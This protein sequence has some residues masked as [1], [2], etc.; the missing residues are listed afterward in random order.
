MNGT[1]IARLLLLLA[2]CPSID[3][4]LAQTNVGRISGTVSDASGA[5]IPG[6]TMV[7]KNTATRLEQT[8]T[9]EEGAFIFPGLASGTYDL[10]VEKEGFRRSEQIGIVLDTASTRTI[11]F[12]LEVGQLVR[13]FQYRPQSSRYRR[14]KVTW[15]TSSV[16]S[17]SARSG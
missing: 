7:A 2:V 1:L 12:K 14:L 16:T 6:C 4:A 15:G 3:V 5:I 10:R 11:D 8:T 17:R 9:D 13:Q